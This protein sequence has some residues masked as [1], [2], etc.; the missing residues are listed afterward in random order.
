MKVITISNHKGGVGKTTTAICLHQE[1]S[2]RGYKVL[3][4]DTDAQGNSSNFFGAD[5]ENVP[6]L[7]DILCRD[8]LA[9][10][11]IQKTPYGDIIASSPELKDIE[12]S[13]RQDERRYIHL[14]RSLR[15]VAGYYDY[16]IM[17][18]P[19]SAGLIIKSCLA[20]SDE[21]IIPVDDDAFSLEGLVDFEDAVSIS[22]ETIN[23]NLK[24]GGIL[25]VMVK[26]TKAS[27]VVN[28]LAQ[29]IMDHLGTKLY[30]TKIR[31]SEA[32]K[33]AIP[34]AHKPLHLYAPKCNTTSDYSDL[35]DELLLA[36]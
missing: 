1:L 5:R 8:T 12:L 19:P 17:D 33:Q 15:S 16:V 7:K 13:V 27:Q 3:F 22:K 10:E 32:C 36:W 20:C 25:L 30:D 11:C 26:R 24:I 23:E 14:K 28:E 2:R 29:T 31:Y 6:T 18:T 9:D 35:V 34:I 4:I 21:V